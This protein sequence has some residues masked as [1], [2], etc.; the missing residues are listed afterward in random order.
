MPHPDTACDPCQHLLVPQADTHPPPTPDNDLFLC[1]PLTL[2]GKMH[3]KFPSPNTNPGEQRPLCSMNSDLTAES[4]WARNCPR[5]VDHG[6]ATLQMRA[7][8]CLQMPSYLGTCSVI[9][10]MA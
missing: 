10:Q 5:W 4:S 1:L 7:P 6:L 2:K 8:S 9:S 3:T